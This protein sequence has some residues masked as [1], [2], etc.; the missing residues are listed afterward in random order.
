[1]RID[2]KNGGM[3]VYSKQDTS[4]LLC[5]FNYGEMK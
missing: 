2:V 1:M 5:V 3:D 4:E